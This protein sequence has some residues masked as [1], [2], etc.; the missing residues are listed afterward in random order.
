MAGAESVRM[1]PMENDIQKVKFAR[2]GAA[3]KRCHTLPIVGEY[4]VGSH[5]F[6]MLSLLRILHPAPSIHLIWAILEHDIPE[7]LTGDIPAPSK[8]TGIVKRDILAFIEQDINQ[9]I[10]GFSAENSLDDEEIMWLKGLD[11]LELFLFCK[12]QKMLGNRN[13]DTMAHRIEKIFTHKRHL[14]APEVVEFFFSVKSHH[15][16][17]MPDIG[18][19]E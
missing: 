16:N 3:V 14:F 9:E 11:I 10:F 19:S 12:D 15:W 6:N 13:L 4:Q 18:D 8:E 5:S 2:E 1:Y 7:R 17:T